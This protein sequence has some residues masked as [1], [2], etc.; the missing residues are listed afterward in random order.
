MDDLTH[1]G[2][3]LAYVPADDR[4]TWVRVAMAVKSEVGDAGFDLWD[5]SSQGADAYDPADARDVWKSVK[6]NG[7]TTIGTLF[8]EAKTHGWRDAGTRPQPTPEELA[9]RRNGA[10]PGAHGTRASRDR[11]RARRSCQ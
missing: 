8:F 9:E 3:A 6:V 5:T 2:E 10:G 11:A 4:E 7:K 1:I